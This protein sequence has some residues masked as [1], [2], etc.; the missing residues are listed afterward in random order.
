MMT[1]LDLANRLLENIQTSLTLR[2]RIPYLDMLKELAEGGMTV[3]TDMLNT[4]SNFGS[5]DT[6]LAEV[7]QVL[8][9]EDASFLAVPDRFPLPLTL[10]SENLK[11]NLTVLAGILAAS[12]A[13]VVNL[14]TINAASV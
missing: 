11:S 8:H 4:S 14:E 10:I 13:L 6:V 12:P 3:S 9:L 7:L 2:S 1:G 5:F